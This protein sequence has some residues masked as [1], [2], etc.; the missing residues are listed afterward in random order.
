VIDALSKLPN[1][2]CHDKKTAHG[3]FQ[4]LIVNASAFVFLL[5]MS[6]FAAPHSVSDTCIPF[7]SSLW[8]AN[9][10]KCR[11]PL[12]IYALS[13][14]AGG[15]RCEDNERAHTNHQENQEIIRVAHLQAKNTPM[16]VQQYLLQYRHILP[17]AVGR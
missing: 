9:Q 15:E 8:V 11:V 17:H 12:E 4:S 16:V 7:V 14:F 2:V 5:A 13:G 6:K 3:P 1:A 10:G